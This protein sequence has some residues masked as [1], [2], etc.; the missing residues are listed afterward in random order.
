[1]NRSQFEH[2][3]RAAAAVAGERE[4]LVIGSQAI[5]PS[6]AGE[7]PEAA[8]RS[9]EADIAFCDDPDDSKADLVDSSIGEA[10]VFHDTYGFYAQG[11]SIATAILPRGWEARLVA[12]ES[13]ST[14]GVVARCLSPGD[15]WVSK[16]LAGRPKDLELCRWL[17]S[18]GVVRPAEV[19]RLIEDTD[20]PDSKKE[21]ASSLLQ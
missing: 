13:P 18:S 3:I 21:L 15:L 20:T 10:S 6:I 11:V 9:V 1:M 14:G 19:A 16:A 17:L 5:H 12:F 8:L 7:L 2:A 4:V